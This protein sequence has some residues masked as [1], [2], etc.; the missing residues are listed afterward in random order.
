MTSMSL[1]AM[2]TKTNEVFIP[3][4][5]NTLIRQK[6]HSYLLL[7][8]RL[9]KDKTVNQLKLLIH[10]QPLRTLSSLQPPIQEYYDIHFLALQKIIQLSPPNAINVL[11]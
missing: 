3:V 2:K 6:Q 11:P 5:N 8:I 9:L 1:Y 4:L 7:E 10:Q